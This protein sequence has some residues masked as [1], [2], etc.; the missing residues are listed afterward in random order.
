[1]VSWDAE[2]VEKLKGFWAEGLRCAEIARRIGGDC[3]RNAVIGK[4]D[5]LQLEKR[6]R[7]REPRAPRQAKHHGGPKVIR[8]PAVVQPLAEP[9]WLTLFD[10]G[11]GQCKYPVTADSPFLFCGHSQHDNSS[12][13]PHHHAVTHEDRPRRSFR[14]NNP[15]PVAA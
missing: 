15:Y 3:T 8:L 6:Q 5:R 12:Y 9:L 14:P 2:T 13:C 4:V 1:M 11:R 7:T 10:L